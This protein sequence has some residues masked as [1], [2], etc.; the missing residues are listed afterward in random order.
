MLTVR[1]TEKGFKF[2]NKQYKTMS[3]NRPTYGYGHDGKP[4]ETQA[5]VIRDWLLVHPGKGIS[6]K[7]CTD[8]FGFTRLSAII[9]IL[10]NDYGMPIK[11]E[12]RDCPTRYNT[13]SRPTF[14]SIGPDD[15]RD[16]VKTLPS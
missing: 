4:L 15:V 2:N 10:K 9:Y 14:Y 13:T 8:M 12:D 16:Y 11:A 7:D 6:Q 5:D 1:P 3:K